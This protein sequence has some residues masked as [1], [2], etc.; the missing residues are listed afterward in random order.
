[1]SLNQTSSSP[2]PVSR[3]ERRRLQKL[4]GKS[5]RDVRSRQ[6]P[7]T[8]VQALL[9]R[10]VA[11][12]TG[13]QLEQAQAAFRKVLSLEPQNHDAHLALAEILKHHGRM[14]DAYE[15]YKCAVESKPGNFEAWRQ[16]GHCLMALK[17]HA[18]A[19]IAYA[20]AAEL[21]PGEAKLHFYV[22]QSCSVQQATDAAISAFDRAIDLRP[23]F[24]EAHYEKGNQLQVLGKFDDAHAC[25]DEALRIDPKLDDALFRV[26]LGR[27]PVQDDGAL[28][29]R[30][31]SIADASDRTPQNRATAGFTV[32]DLL[33]RQ[34]QYSEAFGCY[35]KANAE[36]RSIAGFDRSH[37]VR[38]VGDL[39]DGFN[40]QTF[41]KQTG[42]GS[43]CASPVFIVGMP[44][45]GS[46]LVE[47]ILSSHPRVD[48]VGEFPGMADIAAVLWTE[49][50]GQLSYPR[51]ARLIG[52]GALAE[53]AQGYLGRVSERHRSGADKVCDKYLFNFFNLGL[54]ALLFPRATV[55]H[56]RRDPMDLGLSC[57]MQNFS[58][59]KG[60][61]FTNS[62]EDIGFYYRHY[63]RLMQHWN[64]VLP[65][66]VL[67]VDYEALVADQNDVSREIVAFAGLDW[68]D[69]CLRF[70]E[71]AG[72][73][74]T[75]SVWQVRQPVYGTSSGRWKRYARHLEPLQ[76]T[77][78][79]D[80]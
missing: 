59:T 29:T 58:D 79:T 68:D 77:L 78:M 7:A 22:G 5:Q 76:K 50:K 37:L 52:Q 6:I 70:H 51:D 46:T 31:K 11:C 28:I 66:S 55:I 18:A 43:Q 74:K 42:A 10:G 30:L 57:F 33:R 60:L 3:K 16:F 56:C 9:D 21:R 67:D 36:L 25:Y 1:M 47:R 8:P 35:E 12:L 49:E 34:E 20:N 80:A 24:A 69:R 19:Q 15:H 39:I 32:G 23:D 4:A 54:I 53:M 13:G 71:A 61:A 40:S 65:I 27:G 63:R 75:A 2:Q 44:R 38:I 14:Q 73:V 17:H 26:V 41:R 62:L 45:S 64:D 48:S 72:G